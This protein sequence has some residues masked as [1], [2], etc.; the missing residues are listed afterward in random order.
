MPLASLERPFRAFPSRGAVL[1]LASLLL[2]CEFVTRPPPAQR[3]RGLHDRF[4]RTEPARCPKPTRRWTWTHEPGPWFPATARRTTSIRVSVSREVAHPADTGLA[5]KRPARPLRS[6]APP[7]S[8]FRDDP[9]PWPGRDRR[10]GALVGFFPSRVRSTTVQV[11][12]YAI[13]HAARPEA[14]LPMRDR[15]PSRLATF[16][17]PELRPQVHEPGIRRHEGSIEPRAPPSGSDPAH[18]GFASP[19]APA[20]S[21]AGTS[22]CFVGGASCPCPLSAAPCASR[23]L[24]GQLP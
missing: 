18:T 20:T 1:A 6:F 10:V 8:P 23:A 2:P 16:A 13:T 5:G 24:G 15:E 14:L 22:P 11:R 12:S 3:R 17:R 4:R 19:H 9:M 21:P 7:G